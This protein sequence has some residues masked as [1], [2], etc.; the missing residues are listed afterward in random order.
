MPNFLGKFATDVLGGEEG[1]AVWQG[2][3]EEELTGIVGFMVAREG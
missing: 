1:K 3:L 2:H